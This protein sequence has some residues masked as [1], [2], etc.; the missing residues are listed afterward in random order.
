VLQQLQQQQMD[1]TPLAEDRIIGIKTR[2][3]LRKQEVILDA[4]AFLPGKAGFHEGV[5]N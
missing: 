3:L 5:Q 2:S 4:S 1:G